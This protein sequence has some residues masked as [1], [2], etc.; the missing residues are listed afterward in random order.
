MEFDERIGSSPPTRRSAGADDVA[1]ELLGAVGSDDHD[2]LEPRAL[3]DTAEAQVHGV[4]ADAAGHRARLRQARRR[5]LPTRVAVNVG[6]G[7]Q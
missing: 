4:D 7:L 3:V 6:S 1:G 5:V 2:P